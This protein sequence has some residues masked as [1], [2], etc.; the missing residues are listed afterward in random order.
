MIPRALWGVGAALFFTIIFPP[1]C[2]PDRGSGFRLGV[3]TPFGP[4]VASATD[5]VPAC[6][7]DLRAAS[8]RYVQIQAE[9]TRYPALQQEYR[10]YMHDRSA[11][12]HKLVAAGLDPAKVTAD[13]RPIQSLEP[14]AE[15]EPLPPDEP[16]PTMVAAAED[17]AA[18]HARCDEQIRYLQRDA[19]IDYPMLA[20]HIVVTLM[21]SAVA[22]AVLHGFS[23]KVKE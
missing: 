3:G 16:T 21:I 8:V 14:S 18:A 11:T 6:N 12:I 7:E 13:G 10:Q 23:R 22:L 17:L 5:A 9:W 2:I 19:R 20:Y 1:W 15:A 4:T